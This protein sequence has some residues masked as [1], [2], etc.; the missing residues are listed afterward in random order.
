[1]I[2]AKDSYEKGQLLVAQFAL[3]D[4]GSEVALLVELGMLEV[5]DV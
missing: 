4:E 1:M 5:E 2:Q 3:L